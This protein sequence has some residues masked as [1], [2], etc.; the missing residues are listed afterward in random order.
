MSGLRFRHAALILAGLGGVV[1][2]WWFWTKQPLAPETATPAA[3]KGLSAGHQA[4]PVLASPSPAQAVPAPACADCGELPEDSRL[5]EAARRS[6]FYQDY[7]DQL[8]TETAGELA[9]RWPE[10][11]AR[12]DPDELPAFLGVFAQSLRESGDTALYQE[13]ADMLHDPLAT[14]PAKSAVL[15]LLGNTATPQAMQ[16]L[17]DYLLSSTAKDGIEGTLRESIREA[18]ATLID[19]HWNWDV[20]PVLEKAWRGREQMLEEADRAVLAQGIGYLSTAEGTRA[21]LDTLSAAGTPNDPD[22]ALAASALATL[23][24]NEAV[25]VL[26][27]AL[28]GN[29]SD[30]T[31]TAAAMDAL[32]NIGSADAYLAVVGYLSRVTNLDAGQREAL[33][34]GIA[35]RG[36]SDEAAKVVREAINH[37]AF[38]DAKAKALLADIL[39]SK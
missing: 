19:G 29:Q 8:R 21:L 2:G 9:R 7:A 26:E 11:V 6:D 10:V 27:E 28:A 17:T 5:A 16:V 14:A 25:P 32:V 38:A 18:A 22:R 37:Q 31:V 15:T 3:T 4:Q 33:R 39:V 34:T 13:L 20:S 1:L 24:R 23:Q 12:D 36:L 30:A 35:E